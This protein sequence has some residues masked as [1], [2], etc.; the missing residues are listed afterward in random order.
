MGVRDEIARPYLAPPGL[1]ESRVTMLRRAFDAT[2]VDP[3]FI[4]EMQRQRLEIDGSMT[5][6]ELATAVDRIAE[7]PPAAVQRLVALFNHYK[8]A[9]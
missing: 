9:K 1:P 5:G 7:T 8:E 2:L 6:E 3:A 4:T